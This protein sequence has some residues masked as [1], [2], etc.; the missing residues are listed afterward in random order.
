MIDLATAAPMN[1]VAHRHKMLCH[2]WK[3]NRFKKASVN[4]SQP[5]DSE[6]QHSKNQA[7]HN[8]CTHARMLAA[9]A[10]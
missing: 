5:T 2:A 9:A 1:L 7:P 3:R 4:K 6:I 10:Q 8:E